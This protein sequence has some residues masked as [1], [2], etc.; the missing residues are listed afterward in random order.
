MNNLNRN[1]LNFDLDKNF[2]LQ[3]DFPQCLKGSCTCE[4]DL[5]RSLLL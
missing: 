3:E 4:V 1:N 2:N 5:N